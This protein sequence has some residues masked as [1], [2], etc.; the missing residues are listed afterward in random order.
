MK[1]II[2]KIRKIEVKIRTA[3]DTHKHGNFK[4]VFRGS[5][6]EFDDVRTYQ[7]GDDIRAIDWNVTAKGHGTF[8]KTF[9][10][11]REQNV[12][13]IV[14]V[15]ASLQ[16]GNQGARKLDLA[17]ELAAVLAYSATKQNS[18]ISLIAFSDQKEKYLKPESGLKHFYLFVNQLFNLE[19]K[20]TATNLNAAM[21][22]AA[23]IIKKKSV[24]ILISDFLALD[25]ERPLAALA[26]KHD[27]IVMHVIDNFEIKLPRLGIIPV[28]DPEKRK[29]SWL[30]T[31]SL[32]LRKEITSNFEKRKEEIISICKKNK[33]NY[34]II[35]TNKEYVSKLIK[36][37][38][39]RRIK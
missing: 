9:Q 34:E 20:S 21:S 39:T 24:V 13:F 26:K 27:L 12:Y 1:E 10:E 16:I 22:F 15:S 8:V 35:E 11:D 2:N 29:V 32:R 14:D 17:K 18:N 6:I 25:Y 30:N 33:A 36:L 23:G 7:Y 28:F 19:P 37:F 4:S 31:S 5:G 38:K 3:V